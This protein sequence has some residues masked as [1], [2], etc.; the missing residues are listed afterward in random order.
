MTE[1]S[2]STGEARRVREGSQIEGKP[3]V[4]EAHREGEKMA[5]ATSVLTCGASPLVGGDG[6]GYLEHQG[7]KGRLRGKVVW[8]QNAQRRDSP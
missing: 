5:V 2:W 1:W 7:W 8:P 3:R 6:W 4:G